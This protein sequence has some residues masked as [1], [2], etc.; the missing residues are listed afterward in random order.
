MQGLITEVQDELHAQS[1]TWSGLSNCNKFLEYISRAPLTESLERSFRLHIVDD[2]TASEIPLEVRLPRRCAGNLPAG[3][4][5]PNLYQ[6]V[7][8]QAGQPPAP[9]PA[10]GV[11]QVPV[12]AAAAQGP[13]PVV[14]GQAGAPAPPVAGPRLNLP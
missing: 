12:P 7:R 11:G 9:G 4:G 8:G 5:P 2:P 1:D 14:A 6:R 3:P 13:L 10:A